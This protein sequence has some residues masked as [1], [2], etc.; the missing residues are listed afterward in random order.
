MSEE[1]TTTKKRAAKSTKQET[2]EAYREALERAQEK[3]EGELSPEKKLQ[4][5]KAKEVM[6]VAEAMS[7]EGIVGEINNLKLEIGRL[8]S[9]I[10]AGLEEEVAKYDKIKKAIEVKEQELKELFEI[11]RTAGTLAALV[12]AQNQK[13]E[14]FEEEM[15][16]R[17]EE[18]TKEIEE[19]RARWD[20]ERKE[21]E[22]AWKEMLA[23]EQKKRERERE[24]FLYAFAREQQLARDQF[25]DEKARLEK[26][27]LLKREQL[28][29]ELAEREKAVAE[30]ERE[31]NE[32]R[33]KAAVFQQE[34]EAAVSKAVKETTERLRLEA[35]SREDLLKKEF[36]GEKNVFATRIESL[37]KT[38][39]EQ[40]D[41]I[42]RLSQQLDQSYQKVQDIAV[43]AIEGSSESKSLSTLQQLLA[44]QTRKSSSEK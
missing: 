6:Q 44:E 7:A 2:M 34:L 21:H 12:E 40:A 14:R 11:E 22:A 30:Q 10:A 3:E 43:K 17:K 35:K 1:K 19:T 5:K 23:Q 16:L 31:L 20:R 32:L 28:S 13:R 39:K 25:E 42:A 38:V 4:E 8:L 33:A 9:R 36:E 37:E 41:Q 26:E 24:E 27:I 15:A 29:K 18:L